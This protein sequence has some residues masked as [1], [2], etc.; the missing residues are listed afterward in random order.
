MSNPGYV[1][2]GSQPKANNLVMI[3]NQTE[4]I[5][6]S[7]EGFWVRGVKVEQGPG[8]AEIVYNA[9]KEFLTWSGL[10]RNY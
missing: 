8:E 9:F 3:V 1:F 6:I 7:E 5:K 2:N 10:T 4:W